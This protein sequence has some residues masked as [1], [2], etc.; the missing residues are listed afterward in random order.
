MKGQSVIEKRVRIPQ[1]LWATL[2]LV[3]ERLRCS[4]PETCVEEILAS[5]LVDHR[6]IIT[7]KQEEVIWAPPTIEKRR[8]P[9]QPCALNPEETQKLL[10]LHS[11]GGLNQTELARRFKIGETTV[12]RILD[13][14]EQGKHVLVPPNFGVRPHGP[15][16]IGGVR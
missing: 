15:K 10:H 5:F 8:R 2:E 12:R 7:E 9:G 16:G 6:E 3:S 4:S 13:R 11:T 14:Y 1:A